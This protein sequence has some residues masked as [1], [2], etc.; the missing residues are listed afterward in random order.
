MT[1]ISSLDRQL[2][3]GI[4]RGETVEVFE[5]F[6]DEDISMQENN[7]KPTVTKEA[8]R[9]REQAFASRLK[10]HDFELISSAVKDNVSFSQW[11]MTLILDNNQR[12]VQDQVAVRVWK[13]GKVLHERFFYD[14]QRSLQ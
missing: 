2:N 3:A 12:L 7:E 5:K 9:R 14:N 10:H 13:N 8:N 11:K 4:L 1:E 6:Y